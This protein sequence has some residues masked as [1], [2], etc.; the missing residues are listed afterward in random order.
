MELSSKGILPPFQFEVLKKFFRMDPGFFLTGGAALSEFYLGHRSSK[1]LDLFST[2]DAAYSKG[3]TLLEAVAREMGA[4][5]EPLQTTPTF[6]RYALARGDEQVLV[7]LVRETGYQAVPAKPSWKGIRVD[8]LQDIAANKICTV[9]SRLEPRDYIDLYCLS[10]SGISIDGA[11]PD[12]LLKDG[13]ASKTML[14]HILSRFAIREIPA[15]VRTPL[16]PEE[17][18]KFFRDLADRW[19]LEAAPPQSQKP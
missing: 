14:A 17:I 3:K 19:A 18:Q 6:Q 15:Y 4:I 1:D 11:L 10:R 2:E 13:G 12:A 7:D 9:L 16:S 8:S 5:L